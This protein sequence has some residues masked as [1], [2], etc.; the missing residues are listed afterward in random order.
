MV[1]DNRLSTSQLDSFLDSFPLMSKEDISKQETRIS[2]TKIT[3]DNEK[4]VN[5]MKSDLQTQISL[6]RLPSLK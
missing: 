5:D 4:T 6:Q 2:E 1:V 3:T